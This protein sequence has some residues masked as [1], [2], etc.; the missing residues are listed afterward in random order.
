MPIEIKIKNIKEGRVDIKVIKNPLFE[1]NNL[2]REIF[3]RARA[4]KLK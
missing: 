1:T 3:K 4:I 2:R